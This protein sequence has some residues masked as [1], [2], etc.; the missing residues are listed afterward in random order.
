MKILAKIQKKEESTFKIQKKE[1]IS[2]KILNQIILIALYSQLSPQNLESL[3]LN[4]INLIV[5]T[6]KSQDIPL[7]LQIFT[8]NQFLLLATSLNFQTQIEHPLFYPLYNIDPQQTK[9]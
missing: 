8:I 3:F 4:N 6:L 5:K 2:Y 7:N 1:L 9:E